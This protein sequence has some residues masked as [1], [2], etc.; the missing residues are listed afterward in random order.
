M[1]QEIKETKNIKKHNKNI[2]IYENGRK[3]QKIKKKVKIFK[4]LLKKHN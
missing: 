2:S 4:N 1:F 3:S